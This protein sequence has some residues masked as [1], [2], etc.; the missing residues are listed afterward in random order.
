MLTGGGRALKLSA[1]AKSPEINVPDSPL[2]P[3]AYGHPSDADRKGGG[4]FLHGKRRDYAFPGIFGNGA[5]C[6]STSG[7][8]THASSLNCSLL[9]G[10]AIMSKGVLCVLRSTELRRKEYA[11]MR[12]RPDKFK[13]EGV[14][15]AKYCQTM[16]G[17]PTRR[18]SITSLLSIAFY[19]CQFAVTSP[20][21]E[22]SYTSANANS[23]TSR[24]S[25]P[26]CLAHRLR[27]D[28]SHGLAFRRKGH[29]PGLRGQSAEGSAG[30]S[31]APTPGM[32][33]IQ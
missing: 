27:S 25:G 26:H 23:L 11:Q 31:C 1:P 20:I 22:C 19:L 5:C 30:A 32:S 16:K 10:L 4:S 9:S 17:S 29:S 18:H 33:T 7:S 15:P 6:S 28:P 8:F 2:F 12:T 13:L 24:L 3:Y 14:R 21:R